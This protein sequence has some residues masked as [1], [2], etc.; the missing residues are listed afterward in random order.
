VKT[1][2]TF[3]GVSFSK[4]LN[5]PEAS[6]RKYVFAEHNWHAQIAHERMVRH[7]D[8]VYIR[9][10]HPQLPQ[11]IAIKSARPNLGQ[12][13]ELAKQGKL[14]PAQMDPLL[15]P[16]PAEELFNVAKDYHQ[17]NN[18]AADPK[19]RT[20]LDDLR[21]VMDQWQKQTGDTTPTLQEA[22][23]DRIDRATGK[24]TTKKRGMRP[25]DG[26]VPGETTG[27]EKINNPGPR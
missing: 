19:Y 20:V 15:A 5:D 17:I 21:K 13:R 1:P 4:L 25:I 27:A 10:A 26:V 22:T 23:P 12:L 24:R 3:Q 7:G 16:R 14:T 9:N 2:K 6:I 18:L 8:Y 11:T